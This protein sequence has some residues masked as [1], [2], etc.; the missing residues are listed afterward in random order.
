[1]KKRIQA[2]LNEV[3]TELIKKQKEEMEKVEFLLLF[4]TFILQFR[5]LE[6]KIKSLMKKQALL[7][8]QLIELP[9][10]LQNI[11][12][13][14]SEIEKELQKLGKVWESSIEGLQIHEVTQQPN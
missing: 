14:S 10:I 5:E 1:M 9:I 6:A 2:D 3:K 4:P 13:L 7:E 11:S 12:S 8:E